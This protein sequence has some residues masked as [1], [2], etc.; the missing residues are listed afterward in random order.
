MAAEP[1]ARPWRRLTIQIVPNLF[2][3]FK[4]EDS[5]S[6]ESM[7]SNPATALNTYISNVSSG[8]DGTSCCLASP[9]HAYRMCISWPRRQTINTTNVGRSSLKTGAAPEY[10]QPYSRYVR[11]GFSHS[12][13][14]CGAAEATFEQP[15]CPLPFTPQ[16]GNGKK[17]D[18]CQRVS[19][20][21]NLSPLLHHSMKIK[22]EKTIQM[23]THMLFLMLVSPK[24]KQTA[25][26][27][28]G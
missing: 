14:S 19:G 13:P 25:N 18:L 6:S 20:V 7:L 27:F 10:W 24:T 9:Q 17:M 12:R 4:F 28:E 11:I 15:F 26:F 8:I 21:F 2:S 5:I 1:L 22:L 16:T 3:V 23:N